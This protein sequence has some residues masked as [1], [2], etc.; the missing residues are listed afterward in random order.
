MQLTLKE[1]RRFGVPQA[2]RR[3]VHRPE[4]PDS[5]VAHR[6]I[7]LAVDPGKTAGWAIFDC[8]QIATG[9]LI[10]TASSRGAY[11]TS[12]GYGTSG[13]IPPLADADEVAEIAARAALSR[14]LPFVMAMETWTHG[15]KQD[16]RMTAMT[17][18]GLGSAQ[19][20]WYS[21]F[22]RARS[23]LARISRVKSA[24][25]L[26][27]PATWR[28]R[29]IG[30]PMNRS[31]AEWK[32]AARLHA[33]GFLGLDPSHIIALGEDEA[34]AICIGLWACRAGRVGKALGSD[35]RNRK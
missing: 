29:V 15:G 23:L 3:R 13:S 24:R 22:A 14:K 30:G 26:V 33:A 10:S 9:L 12:G 7:V 18:L 6:A 34:E 8:G 19:A 1:A 2:Q 35:A 4:P 11:G 25:V 28:A 31:T 21:A 17:L 16:R 32:L 20:V 27:N 5:Y